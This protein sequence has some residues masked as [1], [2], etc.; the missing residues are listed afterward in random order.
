M[1]ALFFLILTSA[2]IALA[3]GD[4]SEE[5]LPAVRLCIRMEEVTRMACLEQ[6]CVPDKECAEGLVSTVTTLRGPE[7]G[8]EILKALT[9]D[10]RYSIGTTGH[11][12]AHIVGRETA[13]HTGT[14]GEVFLR[15]PNDFLYGCQH[16][17][18]EEILKKELSGAKTAEKICES[19]PGWTQKQIF[20]CYHGAGHGIVMANAYDLKRSVK[21]CAAIK[22]D[23]GQHGCSQGLFMELVAAEL[24]GEG[25][26]GIFSKR[27]LLAPCD[28]ED[29]FAWGCAINLAPYLLTRTESFEEATELCLSLHKTLRGACIEHFGQL[30]ADPLWQPRMLEHAGLQGS[31]LFIDQAAL[32]CAGM[33]KGYERSCQSGAVEHLINYKRADDAVAFCNKVDLASQAYC[34]QTVGFVLGD[35]AA[36]PI[37]R[38]RLCAS[39]PEA[40]E[41]LCL[42][43][44]SS[45]KMPWEVPT[46]NSWADKLR[47][48]IF[49]FLR[50][51]F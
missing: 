47:R 48:K 42:T 23:L 31:G 17:F 24:R 25:K 8:M 21:A 44:K 10:A 32:L 38:E 40:W 7:D 16:G 50:N 22:M 1:T 41:N 13:K 2:E 46:K 28:I 5:F 27:S 34:F 12:L 49:S 51:L 39:A 26:E 3:H 33:P 35:E 9:E 18:F 14:G 37:E 20:F 30:A 4:G 43:S 11:D 45:V 29:R 19:A 6:V 36:P 15:C